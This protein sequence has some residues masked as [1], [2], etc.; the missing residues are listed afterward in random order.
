MLSL[1]I[2]NVQA[3]LN[4]ATYFD[5]LSERFAHLSTYCPRLSE[6]EKL[7]KESIRLQTSLSNFYAVLVQF[8]TK[9]LK[10]VQEKGTR[11]IIECIQA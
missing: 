7:F 5:K 2:H 6:Y 9:A 8:C 10:V 3:A 11:R 1:L 4:F